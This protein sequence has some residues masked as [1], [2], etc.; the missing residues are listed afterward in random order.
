MES[1]SRTM[2]FVQE[3]PNVSATIGFGAA[4]ITLFLTILKKQFGSII[5]GILNLFTSVIYFQLDDSN[6]DRDRIQRLEQTLIKMPHSVLNAK[7]ITGKSQQL[8]RLEME[9]IYRLKKKK[10]N[11]D[12]P[13]KHI[14]WI[15]RI[16]PNRKYLCLIKKSLAIIQLNEE[17]VFDGSSH[18]VIKIR[19]F[20]LS[21]NWLQNF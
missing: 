15:Q 19:R 3:N 8:I 7:L 18:F 6:E 10:G 14:H 9:L 20:G 16:I 11:D 5:N 13:E 1:I 4:I 17:F 12:L 21:L 2:E